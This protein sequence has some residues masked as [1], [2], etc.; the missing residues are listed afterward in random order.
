M[1]EEDYVAALNESYMHR[2]RVLTTV[3]ENGLLLKLEAKVK[4]QAFLALVAAG[5]N[6]EQAIQLISKRPG[7]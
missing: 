4:R 7:F 2:C 6:G 5:F 1:N 3:I